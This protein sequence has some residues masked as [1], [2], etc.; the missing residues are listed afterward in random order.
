MFLY[1]HIAAHEAISKVIKVIII[2]AQS[3]SSKYLINESQLIYVNI[4]IFHR[5]I[6]FRVMKSLFKL[7]LNKIEDILVL[8]ILSS[9]LKLKSKFLMNSLILPLVQILVVTTLSIK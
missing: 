9:N 3:K 5:N 1:K 7:L 4:F 8:F 2:P 6:L